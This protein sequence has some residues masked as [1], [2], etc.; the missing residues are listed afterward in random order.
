MF[1]AYLALIFLS[2]LIAER[3]APRALA[4]AVVRRRDR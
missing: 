1:M 4:P 3:R 2:L